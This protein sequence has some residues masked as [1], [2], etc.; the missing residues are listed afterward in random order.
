MIG[1]QERHEIQVMRGAGHTLGEVAKLA[2]VSRR[3]VQ[4]V[5]EEA[6]VDHVDDEVE[7]ENRRVGR[8][9]K[10]E[11]FRSFLVEQLATEPEVLSV[12]LLRRA[13]LNGYTGASALSRNDPGVLSRTDPPPARSLRGSC[14]PGRLIRI[15]RLTT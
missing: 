12:E 3:S 13:K 9:S 1:R 15:Q 2:G 10:A 11:P 5:A 14:T 8:P 6:P 7:R 4:R